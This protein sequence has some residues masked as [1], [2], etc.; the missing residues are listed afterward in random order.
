MNEFGNYVLMKY[1]FFFRRKFILNFLKF[2]MKK[3]Y[4]GIFFFFSVCNSKYWVI[5]LLIEV[6][7][8]VVLGFIFFFK[9]RIIKRFI[10]VII[11]RC[12]WEGEGYMKKYGNF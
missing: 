12:L 2:S 11:I 4:E 9:S 8:I 3:E 1:F 5:E 10:M 7:V 6:K